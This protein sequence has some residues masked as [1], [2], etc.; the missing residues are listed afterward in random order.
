MK[1]LAA[2]LAT[3]VVVSGVVS[4]APANT[5]LATGASTVVVADPLLSG[6]SEQIG[7]IVDQTPSRVALAPAGDEVSLAI[8]AANASVGEY[9]PL[10]ATSADPSEVLSQLSSFAPS[11]VEL[12]G[13]PSS[14]GSSFVAALEQ[15]YSVDQSHVADAPFDRAIAA[16]DPAE[17]DRVV[18]TDATDATR[19]ALAAAYAV[20]VGA[21][22]MIVDG[23]AAP[24]DMASVM[25][26]NNTNEIVV[27][28]DSAGSAAFELVGQDLSAKV[29]WLD[30]TDS[31]TME[32]LAIRG[33]ITSGRDAPRVVASTDPG[34]GARA[35]A[36][37]LANSIDAVTGSESAIAEYSAMMYSPLA[38]IGV[39]GQSA[40]AAKVSAIE[41]GQPIPRAVPNFR[42]TDVTVS[43]SDYSVSTTPVTGA[44]SYSAYD[45]MGTL[46]ATSQSPTV[47]VTGDPAPLSITAIDS[48][49]GLLGQV[50]MRINDYSEPDNRDQIVVGSDSDGRNHLR[51]LGGAGVP[52]LINRL[53]V[54]IYSSGSVDV[55]AD[56]ETIA[57]TCAGDFTDGA[58]DGTY[59]YTYEVT[60]LN[61]DSETCALPPTVDPADAQVTGGV[62][63][64]ATE[65]P[66]YAGLSSSP[67]ATQA[68]DAE[69]KADAGQGPRARMSLLQLATRST[70]LTANKGK[71]S[72]LGREP[73]GGTPVSGD[74][75]PDVVFRYQGWIRKSQVFAPQHSGNL[76]KPY[77]YFHGDG[78]A[79]DPNGSYRFQQNVRVRFGSAH[80]QYYDE[81]MGET[82]KY[83]CPTPWWWQCSEAARATASLSELSKTNSYHSNVYGWF[84][85]DVDATN[86]LGPPGSPAIT[87]EMSFIYG[88]GGTTILGYH[89]NMPS[90][91][92]WY[93]AVGWGEWERAYSS[94]EVGL[95]CLVGFIPGCT[96]FV[97]VR[98]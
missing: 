71:G 23:Q 68:P 21:P 29:R 48:S 89:D 77:T 28:G 19:Q 72:A 44:T 93:Y 95:Q 83:K 97:N 88:P 9:I 94:R 4:V 27:V 98:L 53:P 22:L 73:L 59:Q 55:E 96:T 74:D 25:E 14:F 43:A 2:V 31:T 37:M 90:H 18:V 61:H 16:T 20:D 26:D 76:L 30:T 8:A 46:L 58:L 85:L 10:M 12:V 91:E 65:Y 5:A 41:S 80:N 45:E 32:Q 87:A 67:T 56:T 15:T 62:V 39:V 78:R 52:R 57:I 34:I 54:S 63:F 49:G 33:M 69:Q 70:G 6:L 3:G 13:A 84:T 1:R 75:W 11:T 86:P 92:I 51:F 47:T 40:S 36:A 79:E 50:Q 82:I 7:G 24:S 60:T 17:R 81:H 64:P 38:E 35:L 42:A 66:A